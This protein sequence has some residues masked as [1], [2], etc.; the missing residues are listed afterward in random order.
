MESLRELY[1]IGHGPSSSHTMGPAKA[2]RLFLNEYPGADEYKVYL[3]GSLAKTGKGHMTDE[4]IKRSFEGHK[5]N[6]IFDPQKRGLPHANTMEMFAY[7]GGE[8][9]GYWRVYSV[10]GGDI[11]VEGHGSIKPPEVYKL[12]SF[13]AIKAYCY[14]KDIR[15]WQYVEE[16]EGHD[17]WEYLEEVWQTMRHAITEG[18]RAEGT[19]AGGLG[20]ARK[21]KTLYSSNHMD[22][23][24]AT[25]ENRVVCAYA[26]AVSEQNA[27]LGEI[28]TAP[29]CGSC[30]IVPAVLRYI[31]ERKDFTDRE[32][33][34]ALATGGLIGNIIKH[35]ASISGAECGCQA[36]VG[37]ACSMAAAAA[38]EAYGMD[39]DQIEYAAEIA[40]EHHLGLTCDPVGGLVQIPCIERNA[41]AAMRAINAVRLANFLSGSRKISF[42]MVVET[43]YN[44]G[45]DMA[46]NYR[47][48]SEGGLAVTYVNRIK[49]KDK[50]Y[51]SAKKKHL[52]NH[53]KSGEAAGDRHPGP[54]KPGVRKEPARW[55]HDI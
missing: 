30:G 54:K 47:E 45:R 18:L 3:Y 28:V 40:M 23:S 37:S 14:E 25:R 50:K 49:A 16:V 33:L 17:I 53:K 55:G 1:K 2:S 19:L 38:A 46:K 21:A 8:Q 36:E 26:F 9:E 34:H 11:Q 5:I 7:K 20:L 44:T 22:E 43:M 42:D 27:S 4:I 6:V 48:T 51:V 12:N 39:M 10:G 15:L 24:S 35:N 32:I 41:V 29:T 31:Q 52:Y 13:A